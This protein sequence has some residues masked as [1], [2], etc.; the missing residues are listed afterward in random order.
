MAHLPE[1]I[2]Q[3]TLAKENLPESIEQRKKRIEQRTFAKEHLPEYIELRTEKRD[4]T[5]G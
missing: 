5:T 3:R 2:A 1:I 4:H